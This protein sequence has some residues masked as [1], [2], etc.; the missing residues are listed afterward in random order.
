MLSTRS[1][2]RSLNFDSF[3]FIDHLKYK[4][5][6]IGHR[7]QNMI[8]NLH[9]FYLEVWRL[10]TTGFKNT[11]P[12]MKLLQSIILKKFCTNVYEKDFEDYYMLFCTENLSI[13]WKFYHYDNSK[14][15][16]GQ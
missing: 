10:L 1:K 2:F 14:T 16:L 9:T 5:E 8:L 3:Y 12:G 4:S 7:A 15:L 6:F 13:V 11:S